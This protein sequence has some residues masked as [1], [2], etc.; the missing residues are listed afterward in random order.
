VVDETFGAEEGWEALFDSERF[1]QRYLVEG[2]RIWTETIARIE[3]EPDAIAAALRAPWDWWQ[4]GRYENRVELDG[5]RIRY[6]LWP[7]G[8]SRLVHVRETMAPTRKLP[9]GVRR[10]E[11][12][13]EHHANGLAYLE[14]R[15][16]G[17]GS[18]CDL[19]GRFDGCEIGRA[20]PRLMGPRRFAVNHLLAER[21]GLSFP[22]PSGAGWVGLIE[23]LEGR[24]GS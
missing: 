20:L 19:I 8:K 7:V 1:S 5:G 16:R 24:A 3:A 9:E 11:L 6:D 12:Q 2:L 21:G 18:S 4:G 15:P 17:D 14:I 13:L 23:R 10:L 22:F